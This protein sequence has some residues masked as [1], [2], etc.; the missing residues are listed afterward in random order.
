MLLARGQRADAEVEIRLWN[1]KVGEKLLRHAS[2]VVLARVNERFLVPATKGVRE[3]RHLHE[4]RSR[5]HD[6]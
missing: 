1:S 4:L 6:G 2:I 3:D 5:P